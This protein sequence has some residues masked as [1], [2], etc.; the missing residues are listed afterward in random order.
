MKSAERLLST[1]WRR[2]PQCALAVPHEKAVASR[3]LH[4]RLTRCSR[5]GRCFCGRPAVPVTSTRSQCAY[6]TAT[7]PMPPAAA[8]SS[9]RCP[10]RS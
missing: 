7:S 1:S 6:S 10:A 9:A 4:S 2:P 3:E 5:S 8:C